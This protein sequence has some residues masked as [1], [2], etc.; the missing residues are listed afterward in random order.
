M[1]LTNTN[2]YFT[3][4]LHIGDAAV[5]RYDTNIPYTSLE[6]RAEDLIANCR[7][8][9]DEAYPRL[10]LLGDVGKTKRDVERLLAG[11][12]PYWA[13]IHLIR[14][15]H[16]DRAAWALRDKFD[17]ANEALYVRFNKDVKAYMSHYAHRTWRNS[18]HG[19]FH[20]YGHSHGAL[21]PYGRSHD[22]GVNA[23][24]GRP[25]HLRNLIE[26]YK[27]EPTTEHH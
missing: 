7:P 3:S 23:N 8:L 11:I 9:D 1:D 22:V 16:D 5:L 19:S 14:G 24:G 27:A 15:N 21:A 10:W 4:D 17:S 6:E 18:H 20:F 26:K 25:C 2:H 13:E 12:R